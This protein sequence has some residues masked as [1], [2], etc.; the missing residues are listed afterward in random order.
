MNSKWRGLS[1]QGDASIK[2]FLTQNSSPLKEN[3][4]G[5]WR[6]RRNL[7]TC[8]KLGCR[9]DWCFCSVCLRLLKHFSG[10]LLRI[11]YKTF[12]LLQM[13]NNVYKLIVGTESPGGLIKTQSPGSL[14]SCIQSK[15]LAESSENLFFYN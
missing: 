5:V 1:E 8:E 9:E 3:S 13:G 10:A 4:S 12:L 11:P 15:S 2:E 6:V 7:N 14:L